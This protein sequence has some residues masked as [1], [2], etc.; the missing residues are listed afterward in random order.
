MTV[1]PR[2]AERRRV[3]RW[4][5]GTAVAAVLIIVAIV[6]LPRL[7]FPPNTGP[8]SV[9]LPPSLARVRDAWQPTVMLPATLPLC[10]RYPDT[11]AAIVADPLAT[12]GKALR[13]IFSRDTGSGCASAPDPSLVLTEAPSLPSLIGHVDT[14]TDRRMQYARLAQPLDSGQVRVTLQ[15]HCRDLMCRLSGLV[16]PGGLREADLLRMAHSFVPASS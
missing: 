13:I 4:A 16:A 9:A 15:W 10:I 6:L 8:L 1:E 3:P 5:A 12:G 11:G 2:S 7:L 14:V